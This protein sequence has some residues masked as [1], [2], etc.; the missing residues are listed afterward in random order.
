[1]GYLTNTYDGREDWERTADEAAAT[2]TKADYEAAIATAREEG[3]KA[4]L[5]AGRASTIPPATGAP[6]IVQ[7]TEAGA[8][9]GI[10]ADTTKPLDDRCK[11]AFDADDKLRAEFGSLGAL[12]AWQRAHEAGRATV[13]TGST[14][15]V[16]RYTAADFR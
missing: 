7:P 9:A 3:R 8:A 4:G 16:Q 2:I 12:T 1:M 6:G 15:R 11:A 5:D 13:I 10:L 14:G